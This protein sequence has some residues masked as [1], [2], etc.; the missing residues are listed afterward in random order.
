MIRLLSQSLLLALFLQWIAIAAGYSQSCPQP[1]TPDITEIESTS[2]RVSWSV[3]PTPRA[4]FIYAYFETGDTST[5]Q[6]G[7]VS[8]RRFVELSGLKPGTRYTFVVATIC[9][10]GDT[11]ASNFNFF[12]TLGGVEDCEP[13]RNIRESFV[14]ITSASFSWDFGIGVDAYFVSYREANNPDTAWID[15]EDPQFGFLALQNLKP[16]IEYEFF[17]RANCGGIFSPPSRITKFRTGG[18]VDRNCAAPTNFRANASDESALLTWNAST[19]SILDR[20]DFLVTITFPDGRSFTRQTFDPFS[21]L[22]VFDGLERRTE[23][24]AEIIAVCTNDDGIAVTSSPVKIQFRTLNQPPPCNRPLRPRVTNVEQR[25]AVVTWTSVNN[26]LSYNIELSTDGGETWF[27]IDRVDALTYTLSLTPNTDYA[28]RITSVCLGER[29]SEPSQPQTFKTLDD[30]NFC[31]QPLNVRIVEQTATT[32]IIEWDVTPR[33]TGYFWIRSTDMGTNTT[34]VFLFN[35]RAVVTGL[36]PGGFYNFFVAS[37]CANERTSDGSQINIFTEPDINR[38]RPITN[39]RVT[40][41]TNNRVVV[42]WD[43]PGT[44]SRFRVSVVGTGIATQDVSTTSATFTDLSPNTA[45]TFRVSRICPR[46]QLSEPSFVDVTTRDNANSCPVPTV[47]DTFS[48]QARQLSI[49]WAPVAGASSYDLQFRKVGE[50]DFKTIV[51]IFTTPFILTELSPKTRYE[52]RLRTNCGTGSASDFTQVFVVETQP[53]VIQCFAPFFADVDRSSITATSMTLSWFAN[54]DPTQKFRISYI[55]QI[56]ITVSFIASNP[57][58]TVTDLTPE[59]DY[60]FSI[61]TICF[62]ADGDSV[63]AQPFQ[64]FGRTLDADDCTELI[65]AQIT[66][67]TGTSVTFTW[68]NIPAA[69]FYSISYRKSFPLG[70]VFRDTIPAGTTTHTIRNLEPCTEYQFRIRTF[71]DDEIGE[72]EINSFFT[73]CVS[74]CQTPSNVLVEVINNNSAFVSWEFVDNAFGYSIEIRDVSTGFTISRSSGI[75]SISFDDLEDGQ[76]EVTVAANCFDGQSPPSKPVQFT[77]GSQRCDAPVLPEV[78]TAL[79]GTNATLNFTPSAQGLAYRITLTRGGVPVETVVKSE[80]TYTFLNLIPNTRYEV[81]I[82]TICKDSVE[83]IRTANNVFETSVVCAAPRNLRIAP[84]SRPNSTQVLWDAVPSI[85]SYVF[86]YRAFDEAEFKNR[87]VAEPRITLDSLRPGISY[88]YRICVLC[89][90]NAVPFCSPEAQFKTETACFVP[91]NIKVE[92]V[93]ET[94]ALVSW[95]VPTP[96]SILS[97]QVSYRT[98]STVVTLPSTTLRSI[99]LSG[100]TPNSNY[101]VFVRSRCVDPQTGEQ[102]LSD[103]TSAGFVT[104]REASSCPTPTRVRIN[105]TTATTAQVGWRFLTG[106]FTYEVFLRSG[107]GG[108]RPVGRT[109]ENRFTITGLR[110]RDSFQV[111]VRT[112][113]TGDLTSTPSDTIRGNT[114]EVICVNPEDVEVFNVTENALSVRWGAVEGALNY[115]VSISTNRTTFT[116]SKADVTT[117]EFRI[118]DL[119]PNTT[120][121]VR[122][123]TN[124]SATLRSGFSDTITTKTVTKA[125]CPV[126]ATIDAFEITQTSAIIRWSSVTGASGYKLFVRGPRGGFTEVRLSNPRATETTLTGLDTN[127]VYEVQV[128]SQC[129]TLSQFR[130]TQ[131]ATRPRSGCGVPQRVTAADTTVGLT[132]AWVTWL[133]VSGAVGYRVEFRREA[134]RDFTIGA[135]FTSRTDAVLTGMT[136]GTAYVVRVVAICDDGSIS[137]PS[138]NTRFTTDRIDG[139]ARPTRLT[140]GAVTDSSIAVRWTAS[141]GARSYTVWYAPVGGTFVSLPPVTRTDAIISGLMAKKIYTIVVVSNCG[142][143]NSSIPSDSVRAETNVEVDP[144]CVAPANIKIVPTSKTSVRVEWTAIPG[145]IAYEVQVSVNNGRSFLDFG[146][147]VAPTIMLND[148]TR[149]DTILVQVRTACTTETLSDFSTPVRYIVPLPSCS[150]PT[151]IQVRAINPVTLGLTWNEVP[152]ALN[153]VVFVSKDNGAT[154]PIAGSSPSTSFELKDVTPGERLVF[155]VQALCEEDASSAPSPNVN[156]RVPA[157]TCAQPQNIRTQNITANSAMALWDEIENVLEYEVTITYDAGGETT[158][159]T[160]TTTVNEMMIKDIPAGV[161]VRVSVR[162]RCFANVFSQPST[163]V[164]STLNDP[165]VCTEPT[166]VLQHDV[167]ENS[168]V[169]RWNAVRGAIG[170]DVRYAL[171]GVAFTAPVRVTEP[172]YVMR[173]LSPGRDYTVLVRTI[174][175]ESTTSDESGVDFETLNSSECI[176][177]T[178]F[179]TTVVEAT[180]LTLTW[181]AVPTAAGYEVV[182][183]KLGATEW[184][185]E[186]VSTNVLRLAGLEPNATYYVKVRARCSASSRVFTAFTDVLSVMTTPMAEVACAPPA[187]IRISTT[188]TSAIIEWDAVS[189]A[190]SYLVSYSLRGTLTWINLTPWTTSTRSVITDLT[191]GTEYMVR[192]RSRCGL[193]TSTPS[194]T[195]D[196]RTIGTREGLAQIGVPQFVLYPNPN[197][198]VFSI[199]FEQPLQQSATVRLLDLAGKQVL[200]QSIDAAASVGPIQIETNNL[201]SGVYLL[202]CVIGNETRHVRLM[203]N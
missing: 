38:C 12:T 69:N 36:S 116:V 190:T 153:Y 157:F 184:L 35:N 76:Y 47:V 109:T 196:F 138:P 119:K 11:S 132:T 85:T 134:D 121:Y 33:A 195:I 31:P 65:M 39:F 137:D 45:Y 89:P 173:G 23:Y 70:T 122:V 160:S 73:Q 117:T 192:V 100:L 200:N 152:M 175:S 197:Q 176:T 1:S 159:L 141:T 194:S 171:D 97:Y 83:S 179:R 151:N 79:D 9:A 111:Y 3:Q 102:T 181:D 156:F 107:T 98:G 170:Y 201:S 59:T 106:A 18:A 126:P 129:D 128:Q 162:S 101:T 6:I 40:E 115:E 139:C 52:I 27:F 164:F 133:R 158:R 49:F 99:V 193:R 112:I 203:I 80:T 2:A 92:N 16:D 56:G 145:I 174:C 110:E 148:L 188:G 144:G 180:T 81:Q 86:Q 147:V 29:T 161:S 120:Y 57:P 72:P 7:P 53:E 94:S 135:S 84:G 91:R 127:A 125:A 108:F 104:I 34:P 130:T 19:P 4:R 58:F 165:E 32:A 60:V 90:N 93:T 87:N 62:N 44:P 41:V 37:T 8:S 169:I 48:V 166:N 105:S 61:E 26:A 77:I 67:N 30:P 82:R 163:T 20:Q 178:N 17:I 75:N 103:S 28:V 150:T 51:G 155:R 183:Q 182:Y 78:S 15:L 13:P 154:F 24:S 63:F 131:F 118:T 68:P 140:V 149:G 185:V 113:C 189:S 123:R 74:S 186:L 136:P 43:S 10:T 64:V 114:G 14:G 191:P 88:T 96:N 199:Q 66:E 50:T 146:L 167:A 168:A 202:E 187:T 22:M 71:C 21:E 177:P 54:F 124:C 95:E 5:A 25:S 42:S 172:R 198:G 46:E 142:T 143:G 55:N